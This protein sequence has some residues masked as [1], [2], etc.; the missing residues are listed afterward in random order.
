MKLSLYANLPRHRAAWYRTRDAF[1]VMT[2]VGMVLARGMWAFAVRRSALRE[3][4]PIPS[5]RDL[6]P[7]W[8]TRSRP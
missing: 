4:E 7:S 8:I 5:M 3:V 6:L 2:S 1:G